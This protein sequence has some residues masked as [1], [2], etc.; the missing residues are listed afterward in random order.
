MSQMQ[1]QNG[2][3]PAQQALAEM[4]VVEY[5]P[6]GAK[7]SI[8]LTMPIVRDIVAVKTRKGIPP[9][10]QQIMKF[11]LL[12]KA[13]MLNP[14]EGDAFLIGFDSGKDGDPPTFQLIT[15]HQAFLKRAEVH[16]EY[17]GMESGVIV[18]LGADEVIQKN[19]YE[20]TVK[21]GS[22]FDREGDF[23]LET[24]TLLGAWA[25]VHFKGRTHPMKK[26]IR[27]AAFNKGYG[28][29]K[30]DPAGM[31]V[32]VAES[33]SLRSSFPTT[34]GALYLEEEIPRDQEFTKVET[35]EEQ[36]PSGRRTLRSPAPEKAEPIVSRPVPAHEEREEPSQPAKQETPAEY[37]PG[38]DE[39]PLDVPAPAEQKPQSSPVMANDDILGKI[40][41]A[42][43]K[44]GK[45]AKT[46]CG[47]YGVR[48]LNKLT[49]EQ[50]KKLLA[51]LTKTKD[52]A[53]P[54]QQEELGL[55]REPGEEG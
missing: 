15:A 37:I 1:T 13:R 5:I 33:D 50:A 52:K 2:V 47:E 18:K 30:D 54:A 11:M 10:D 4:K 14:F 36:R 51:D 42:I 21:S 24:D 17:D 48:S 49:M 38:V 44:A 9:T 16:P 7:S 43:V 22:I 3:N 53:T 20:L 26:R 39:P 29:W 12:C 35:R 32:K 28:R 34:L 45:V 41:M 46:V 6:F 40:E 23:F 55:D 8:K 31:C 25:T 19:G 27:L